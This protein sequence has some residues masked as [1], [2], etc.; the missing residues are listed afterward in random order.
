[1]IQTVLPHAYHPHFASDRT[2]VSGE[3]TGHMLTHI[4]LC[5]SSLRKS[6]LPSSSSRLAAV[7]HSL[8]LVSLIRTRQY[9]LAYLHGCALFFGE[10]GVFLCRICFGH[11]PSSSVFAHLQLSRYGTLCQHLD[12]LQI[13]HSPFLIL[14]FAIGFNP[15]CWFSL[16]VS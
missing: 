8:H 3:G 14:R 2:S 11:Q 16:S 6:S 5:I 1:M 15:M 12:T 7:A 10:E 9:A 4:A 13:S